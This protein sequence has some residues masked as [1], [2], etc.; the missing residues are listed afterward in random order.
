MKGWILAIAAPYWK[1]N[2]LVTTRALRVQRIR[3][4]PAIFF[5]IAGTD[6]YR[7]SKSK[8]VLMWPASAQDT[9]DTRTGRDKNSESESTS[10]G[11][12]WVRGVFPN[13][14]VFGVSAVLILINEAGSL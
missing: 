14:I 10:L 11:D 7:L 13:L 5:A 4:Y 8:V 12:V 9:V 3:E 2:A 1:G 6:K